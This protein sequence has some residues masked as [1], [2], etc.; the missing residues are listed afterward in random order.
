MAVYFNWLKRR[1]VIRLTNELVNPPVWLPAV[2]KLEKNKKEF[3]TLTYYAFFT[4]KPNTKRVHFTSPNIYWIKIMPSSCNRNGI[5]HS[6]SNYVYYLY[7][8][9]VIISL[10]VDD[11]YVN[12]S[13]VLFIIIDF[14]FVC[15][16]GHFALR[17]ANRL[18]T[19]FS[20]CGFNRR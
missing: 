9:I 7:S 5:C 10:R 12:V 3:H 17:S 15:L 11:E 16:A 18:T 8:A 19:P 2:D 4:P 1:P 20:Y 14:V 6:I 13:S